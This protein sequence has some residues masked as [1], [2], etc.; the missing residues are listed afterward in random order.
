LLK[1][2]SISYRVDTNFTARGLRGSEV[3]SGDMRFP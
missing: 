2:P 3:F 1:K